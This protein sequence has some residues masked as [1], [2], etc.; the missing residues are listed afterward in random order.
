LVAGG[1]HEVDR[2]FEYLD[3]PAPASAVAAL[4][5]PSATAGEKSHVVQGKDRLTG[6]SKRLTNEQIDQ[7]LETVH[8]VGVQCYTDSLTP[9]QQHLPLNT[10]EPTLLR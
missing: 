2:I 6:W 5:T 8:A 7:I 9:E 4:G 1:K 3:E 10:D